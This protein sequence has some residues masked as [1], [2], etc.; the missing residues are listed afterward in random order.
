MLP[1]RVET[2]K[3]TNVFRLVGLDRRP[4]YIGRQMHEMDIQKK[5]EK[6]LP[7]SAPHDSTEQDHI[8]FDHQVDIVQRQIG[9]LEL[10]RIVRKDGT[11]DENRHTDAT[12]PHQL[13][14]AFAELC[15]PTDTY[16]SRI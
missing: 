13:W 15:T 7:G 6:H 5:A 14:R 1:F 10:V 16:Q 2:G 11:K 8:R 12:A 3:Q 4:E 9:R